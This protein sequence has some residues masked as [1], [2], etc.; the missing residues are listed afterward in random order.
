MSDNKITPTIKKRI[1]P[2]IVTKSV[3]TEEPPVDVVTGTE[4]EVEDSVWD[5]GD[6][7]DIKELRERY[8]SDSYYRSSKALINKINKH[9]GW[10][11]DT[12]PIREY[13]I[14]INQIIK[15]I[16]N[17]YAVYDKETLSAKLS[18]ICF[19]LKAHGYDGELLRKKDELGNIT[20]PQRAG[21]GDGAVVKQSWD[22][23]KATLD[24]YVKGSHHP[25][26]RIVALTY[27]YGYLLPLADI[28][29]T[30]VAHREQNKHF[31]DLD[32]GVWYLAPDIDRNKPGKEF[33]V[34]ADYVSK[35][36]GYIRTGSAW[37]ISKKGGLPYT[38]Q[39]A[40]RHLDLAGVSLQDV[41]K[42]M[43]NT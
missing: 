34:D 39:V 41:R 18:A 13:E 1:K 28:V 43:S 9:F 31:L 12:L 35:I 24:L 38:S 32:S 29:K 26:G 5:E 21:A 20:Y 42:A 15:F 7:V 40:M 10:Q 16:V 14:H 19:P 2:T 27:K 30:K 8:S 4:E 37:L 36:K 11:P 3:A 6:I 23:M 33:Q 17:N 25:G 22:E